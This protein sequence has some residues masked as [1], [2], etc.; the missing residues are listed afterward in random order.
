VRTPAEQI[1]AEPERPVTLFD[2]DVAI[3]IGLL[4]TVEGELRAGD[5]SARLIRR[6]TN[7]VTRLGLLRANEGQDD[8][9]TVLSD[10]NQRL[11]VARG[12]SEGVP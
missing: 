5:A 7:D 8:L 1:R 4:A 3:L 2:R 10:L 12:E 11:R 9:V 6:L